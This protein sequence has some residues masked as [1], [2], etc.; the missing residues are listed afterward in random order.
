MANLLRKVVTFVERLI[1]PVLSKVFYPPSGVNI[2]CV[3]NEE[4]IVL[5]VGDDYT[6]PG[7]MVNANEHPEQTA[8]REFKEETGLDVAIGD[9]LAIKKEF[10]GIKGI[11]FFYRGY[12]KDDFDNFS[13]SWE[14][15]PTKIGKNCLRPEMQEIIEKIDAKNP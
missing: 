13:E 7:G 12:L 5:D 9:L 2:V 11:N 10:N 4:V 8:K 1:S 15:T 14:G 3:E 6:F